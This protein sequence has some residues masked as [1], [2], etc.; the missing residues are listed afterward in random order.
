MKNFKQSS[1]FNDA[2]D[3][4]DELTNNNVSARKNIKDFTN[5]VFNEVRQKYLNEFRNNKKTIR[6]SNL[7]KLKINKNLSKKF[8]N[9]FKNFIIKK[10][11]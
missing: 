7:K 3:F 4:I 9:E 11:L 5:P 2:T 6:V 1:F 10:G 8:T